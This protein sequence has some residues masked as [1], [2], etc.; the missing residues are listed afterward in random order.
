M[1]HNLKG[2]I[3]NTWLQILALIFKDDLATTPHTICLIMVMRRKEMQ[4]LMYYHTLKKGWWRYPK[5]HL[6]KSLFYCLQWHQS[7]TENKKNIH[8]NNTWQTQTKVANSTIHTVLL[9]TIKFSN[10]RSHSIVKITSKFKHTRL[11][12][13][14]QWSVY[15]KVIS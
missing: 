15:L 1:H 5:V 14:Y 2:T 11:S 10:Y 4:K 7:N 8:C 12:T 9:Y 3:F 6:Q 13:F